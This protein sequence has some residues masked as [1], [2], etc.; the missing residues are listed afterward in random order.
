VHAAATPHVTCLEHGES[1]H[2][3]AVARAPAGPADGVSVV[4]SANE[5]E[6]HGHE[7]CGLQGQRTTSATA[8]VDASSLASFAPAA[9]VAVAVATPPLHLLRLAPKTSPPRAPSA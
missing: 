7:H 4:A 5:A 6:A 3:D 8:P 9:A 1:V 2:L